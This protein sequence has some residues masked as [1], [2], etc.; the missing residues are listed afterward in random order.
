MSRKLRYP[1]ISCRYVKFCGDMNRTEPCENRF[2]NGRKVKGRGESYFLYEIADKSLKCVGGADTVD[3][4]K[5]TIEKLEQQD[6]S[7]GFQ[8]SYTVFRL[9]IVTGERIGRLE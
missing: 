7:H 6:K 1:C 8:D 9:N 4:A 2:V 3:E 5:A